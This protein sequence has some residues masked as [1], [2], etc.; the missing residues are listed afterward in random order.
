MVE[1]NQNLYAVS[2]SVKYPDKAILL[3][4]GECGFC[5]YWAKRWHK[6]TE[7]RVQYVSYQ[8][9]A[10]HFPRVSMEAARK[11]VHLITPDGHTYYAAEAVFRALAL[12]GKRRYLLWLYKNFPFFALVSERVYRLVSRHRH[13]FTYAGKSVCMPNFSSMEGG[14]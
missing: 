5:S 14:E 11:A 13:R 10:Q 8:M 6:L 9:H 2:S 1:S 3:Y 4:D 7:G 12:G